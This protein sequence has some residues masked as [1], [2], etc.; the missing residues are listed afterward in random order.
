M[1]LTLNCSWFVIIADSMWSAAVHISFG[2]RRNLK[3]CAPT[4]NFEKEG[5]IWHF[6][7]R[8]TA[9]TL[10]ASGVRSLTPWPH[11]LTILPPTLPLWRHHCMTV[12][13]VWVFQIADLT[14]SILTELRIRS[15][16]DR[17]SRSGYISF[18]DHSDHRS[19]RIT[20][21]FILTR[22]TCNFW[23]RE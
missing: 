6:I 15:D 2:Y 5:K 17:R 3:V 22:S 18:W 4:E 7:G 20:V 19:D 8:L 16:H 23:G 13:I 11:A 21:W 12:S 14:L 10:S 9:K 1:L